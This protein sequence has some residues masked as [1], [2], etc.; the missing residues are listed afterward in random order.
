MQNYEHRAFHR[1]DALSLDCVGD[2]DVTAFL[3]RNVSLHEE[4]ISRRINLR[5][6]TPKHT[7][8]GRSFKAPWSMEGHQKIAA[9]SDRARQQSQ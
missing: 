7:A 9:A 8:E 5:S 3:P 2:P 4:Q 1:G 6:G